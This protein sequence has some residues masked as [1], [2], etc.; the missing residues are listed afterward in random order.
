MAQPTILSVNAK[1]QVAG[2][3][4]A[5][6]ITESEFQSLR[7]S[8]VDAKALAH[9]PYSRF[10]VGAALLCPDGSIEVGANVENASYPVGTCA[11]R[12]AIGKA[13]TRQGSPVKTFRAIAVST[14]ISPPASPCGMCRQL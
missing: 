12:V 9:C 4:L 2:A 8:A 1:D 10:R 3:C 13:V 5:H 11:E 14:D 6:N 7:T